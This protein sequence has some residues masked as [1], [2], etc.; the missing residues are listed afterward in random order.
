MK[1]TN[2]KIKLHSLKKIDH[3]FEMREKGTDGSAIV[4]IHT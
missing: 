4:A 1:I 3:S 2:F